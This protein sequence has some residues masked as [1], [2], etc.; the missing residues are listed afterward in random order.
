MRHL[1]LSYIA[2]LVALGG[3]AGSSL[4]A[5]PQIVPIHGAD[6]QHL[7]YDVETGKVTP[8]VPSSRYGH[9]VWSCPYAY[10]NYFWGAEPELGEMGL[11]WGDVTGPV[12]VGG[13]TFVD[14]TNSW[15]SD[16]DC[17]AIIAIYAEENG[18]NSTGRTLVA[19]FR[20]DNVPGAYDLWPPLGHIWHVEL[21]TPF[22]LD[23]SDLDTDGLVDWGYAQFFSVRTPGA[24]HGPA[25]CGLLEPN[26]LP[27]QCPGVE[28]VFDLFIGPNWNNDPNAWLDDDPNLENSFVGT[29]W[30]GGP[31]VFAQFCFELFAYQCPN[32]G[33]AGR[34]CSADIDGSFDCVVG[35]SDLAVLLSNYGLTMGATPAMGDIEPYHDQF[36]GDG[37]V[38]AGDLA[39]LLSQ[40]GDDCNGP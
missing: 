34:Y 19:G 40:Y 37:D 3:L 16:G 29:Y 39:E 7:H 18:L 27:P 32:V 13:V 1:T 21:D 5:G 14:F 9:A 36:P 2:A 25:I 12:A 8:G 30:F 26:N 11:D 33:A 38:D 31:P 15:V 35:L 17:Y 23:G 4:F 24:L 20:I 28:D 10:S 22:V 6:I